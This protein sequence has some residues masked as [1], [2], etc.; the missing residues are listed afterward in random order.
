MNKENKIYVQALSESSVMKRG[1]RIECT[2]AIHMAFKWQ[3]KCN[4]QRILLFAGV[5]LPNE[6]KVD[7]LNVISPDERE[8]KCSSATA[9]RH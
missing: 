2:H 1:W 7:W 6:S 8:R 9:T 5:P 3:W 4:N